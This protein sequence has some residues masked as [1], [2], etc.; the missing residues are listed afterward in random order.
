MNLS[1]I[2][3]KFIALVAFKFDISKRTSSTNEKLDVLF[4]FFHHIYTLCFI[5]DYQF[6]LV[7]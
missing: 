5:N 7:K 6:I 4:D 2:L 3:N 1:V